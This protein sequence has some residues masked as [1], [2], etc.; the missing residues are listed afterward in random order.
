MQPQRGDSMVKIFWLILL[1]TVG[2][3]ASITDAM[4][5]IK[6]YVF[7]IKGA[8]FAVSWAYGT[9]PTPPAGEIKLIWQGQVHMIK[10][11]EENGLFTALL[12]LPRCE[13]GDVTYEVSGDVEA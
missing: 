5:S 7:T 9:A 3:S 6:P 11:V 2:A 12:P 10:G 1:T 13:F 4:F 8:K